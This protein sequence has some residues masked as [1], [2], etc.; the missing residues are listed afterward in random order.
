MERR[1]LKEIKK[2][3]EQHD[4]KKVQEIAEELVRKLTIEQRLEKKKWNKFFAE[5]RKSWPT[6]LN[7]ICLNIEASKK[8]GEPI[9]RFPITQGARYQKPKFEN[10]DYVVWN[11]CKANQATKGYIYCGPSPYVGKA[12]ISHITSQSLLHVP[13]TELKKDDGYNYGQ[14]VWDRYNKKILWFV[15]YHAGSKNFAVCNYSKDMSCVDKPIPIKD[16]EPYTGQDKPAV[17]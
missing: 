1:Q 2:A 9:D 3:V 7:E 10:G 5:A 12:T 16:I 8:I 15:R 13:Y 4:W 6:V 17:K 11:H 14:R